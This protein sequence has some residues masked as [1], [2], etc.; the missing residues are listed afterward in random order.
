MLQVQRV[1]IEGI[2]NTGGVFEPI[3]NSMILMVNL[4]YTDNMI[5]MVNL[6]YTDTIILIVN[7]GYTNNIILIVIRTWATLATSS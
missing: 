5:L 6:R 1:N 2:H 7:M 3:N 4:G